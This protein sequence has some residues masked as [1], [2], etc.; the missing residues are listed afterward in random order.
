MDRVEY[1]GLNLGLNIRALK[2]IVR[3]I[4]ISESAKSAMTESVGEE[5]AVNILNSL[6]SIIGSLKKEVTIMVTPDRMV[7]RV[8]EKNKTS[9]ISAVTYFDQV[10]QM[11]DKYGL[12]VNST[13]FNPETGVVAIDTITPK[14]E[15]QVSHHLDEVFHGGLSISLNSDGISVD[16][17]MNR[18]VCTNGMVTR[19]F[20]E[21]FSIRGLTKRIWEE[22]HSYLD[23]M[24]SIGFLPSKFQES[25]ERSRIIP[26]SLAEVERGVSLLRNNSRIPE[27]QLEIFFKGLRKTFTGLHTAGIDTVTLNNDQKRNTRTAIKHWDL[28]NGITDFASHDYGYE[29]T[30][31]C[32]WRYVG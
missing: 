7:S 2:D 26:A 28:I 12:T 22:F 16:P 17:Y 3:I 9:S 15:F 21:S 8:Q 27:D 25:V 31:G 4:G 5:K 19:N 11:V 13:H 29:K 30:P 32:N 24:V 1:A 20:E 18:L 23:R 6:K 14:A 10:E